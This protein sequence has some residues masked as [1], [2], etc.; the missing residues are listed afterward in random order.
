MFL[1]ALVTTYKELQKQK[2]LQKQ[3]KLLKHMLA[4]NAKNNFNI[5]IILG[6]QVVLKI[7]AIGMWS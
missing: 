6:V 1:L 3:T 4:H 7:C 5:T 2:K